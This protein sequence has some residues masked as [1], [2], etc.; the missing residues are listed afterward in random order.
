MKYML[1]TDIASYLVKKLPRV[2]ERA[3]ASLGEWCVSS[4]VY[5]ELMMGL[6]S[7]KSQAMELGYERFL[8]GV[9]V[10][11]FGQGAAMAAAELHNHNL[12]VGHNIGD[13]DNLIAGHAAFLGLTLVTNNLKHFRAI[14][15][16]QVE[17]W[18]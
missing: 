7:T 3:N 9:Q 5:Q 18:V 8:R 10:V 12:S 6:L 16:L 11:E 2:V 15:G 13:R 14:S 4:I 1:D 17:T